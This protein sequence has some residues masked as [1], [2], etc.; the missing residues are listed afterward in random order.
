V[1]QKS[2]ALI[3]AGY[4]AQHQGMLRDLRDLTDVRIELARLLDAAEAL[5]GLQLGKIAESGPDSL[6]AEVRVAWPLLFIADYLWARHAREKGLQPQVM[7]GHDVGEYAA[8]AH[9]GVISPTAALELV[10]RLSKLLADAV[11]G[12]DGATLVVLGLGAEEVTALLAQQAATQNQVWISCD[13][14]SDQLTLGGVRSVLEALTPSLQ[15]AGAR[16]TFFAPNAGAFNTPL[17]QGVSDAYRAVLEASELRNAHIPVIM[18]ATALTVMQ[19]PEFA[20]PLLRQITQTIRWR[21][22]CERIARMEPVIM[23]ESGPGSTLSDLN[24]TNGQ[25]EYY[26]LAQSG[27]IKLLNRL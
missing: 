9:A 18:N 23:V 14:S 27:I 10:I 21:E 4:G 3:F 24:D 1:S 5:S 19:G 8:L 16:Q 22:T 6:L 12:S 11:S 20:D 17:V 13:Q 7:A 25:V 2:L 26:S 15:N